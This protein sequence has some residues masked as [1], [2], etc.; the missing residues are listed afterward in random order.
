M[1]E[2]ASVT[3]YPNTITEESA[4]KCL[5]TVLPTSPEP[6]AEAVNVG[7]K[8]GN[9]RKPS[10]GFSMADTAHS[11][12]GDKN[13]VQNYF[14]VSSSHNRVINILNHD[15]ELKLRLSSGVV[16]WGRHMFNVIGTACLTKLCACSSFLET[17][18]SACVG[19]CSSNQR[20]GW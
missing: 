20:Y 10:V 4:G 5:D 19:K 3:D 2:V 11:T 15:V 18:A 7:V 9:S 8:G 16:N 17:L 14:K 13:F 12:L 1:V 6:R